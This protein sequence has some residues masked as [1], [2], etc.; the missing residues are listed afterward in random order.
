MLTRADTDRALN[1]VCPLNFCLALIGE[2]CISPVSGQPVP[3]HQ[4]RL[5][6]AGVIAPPVLPQ[7]AEESA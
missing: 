5:V 7:P 6:K 2:W 3:P 1:V 4:H